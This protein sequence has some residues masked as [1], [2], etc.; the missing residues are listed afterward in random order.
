MLIVPPSIRLV[1]LLLVLWCIPFTALPQDSVYVPLGARYEAG[2]FHRFWLGDIWR[3]AWTIPVSLPVLNIHTYNGGLTPYKTGGGM[4]TK[5]LRFKDPTGQKYK[6]R[7]VDKDPARAL[8]ED[9]QESIV[10]WFMQDQ[11]ATSF[12]LAP[13]LAYPIIRSVGIQQPEP[14]L[15]WLPADSALGEYLDDFGGMVGM[16]EIIPEEGKK[17]EPGYAGNTKIIDTYELFE[18]IAQHPDEKP[19]YAGYLTAR[20]TDVL[21]G[22]WDRH[23]GQWDWGRRADDIWIPFPK[24]RDRAF[25]RFDGVIPWLTT[26]IIPQWKSFYN[27]YP[28]AIDLTWSGRYIDRYFLSHLDKPLWDSVTA[29]VIST[30]SDSLVRSSVMRLPEEYRI[31]F[32]ND[33]AATLINRRETLQYFSGQFY[34]L[35]NEVLDVYCTGSSDRVVINRLTD[36]S[37]SVKVFNAN[38]GR[39]VFSRHI[40]HSDTEELRIYLLGGGD[41]VIVTGNVRSGLIIKVAGGEGADVVIDSSS[42]QQLWAGILPVKVKKNNTLFFDQQRNSSL[43]D[44]G[45]A[46][47]HPVVDT[48]PSDPIERFEPAAFDRG[49]FPFIIPVLGFGSSRGFALGG[50]IGFTAFDMYAHPFAAET[51]FVASYASRPGGVELLFDHKNRIWHRGTEIGFRLH[52]SYQSI[53]HFFG[54]G[55]ESVYNRD[56]AKDDAYKV[57]QEILGAVASLTISPG[58]P[59]H[60]TAEAALERLTTSLRNPVLLSSAPYTD[61]G[62]GRMDRLRLNLFMQFDTRDNKDNAAK[63][64]YLSA[65][66]QAFIGLR[67]EVP[68]FRTAADARFFIRTGLP[69]DLVLAQRFGGEKVF[70]RFPFFSGAFIGDYKG[71]RG[72][73]RERFV[74]EGSLF[75]QTEL[76][77]KLFRPKII[78]R[79]D[80]GMFGFAETARVFASGEPSRRWHSSIG[81]GLWVSYLNGMITGTAY[82]AFSV[83]GTY[84][85][86]D[87][88]M[89]F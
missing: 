45:G 22:D 4:Q 64:V 70:G 37:T 3:D 87:S 7:S 26:M 84:L 50:G 43:S 16:L 40:S 47:F 18:R 39:S 67:G 80:L 65:L 63:G 10:S 1:I 14:L 49:T 83:D 38:T 53:V 68:H 61:Y 11:T 72:F 57:E 76:R 25:S 6:F 81:A 2:S 36:S 71:L 31:R 20:L 88:R 44:V 17:K 23:G 28:A 15:F 56:V 48:I 9:V 85:S 41:T 89:A 5:S 59:F 60:V 19:D 54:F 66:T 21:I 73:S 42:I 79:C 52:R 33:I 24:D 46:E 51:R 55:N 58:A 35:V 74:G 77:V 62:I 32:G 13:L 30:V 78:I 34:R 86:V 69:G 82:A 75:S 29:F 12:P 27:E 8:P